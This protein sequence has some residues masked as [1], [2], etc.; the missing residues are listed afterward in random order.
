MTVCA[1]GIWRIFKDRLPIVICTGSV[2]NGSGL[3]GCG[4]DLEPDRIV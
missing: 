4:P 1:D 3:H 2:S